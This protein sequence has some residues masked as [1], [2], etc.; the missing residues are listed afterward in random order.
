MVGMTIC[1]QYKALEDMKHKKIT[2]TRPMTMIVPG[3]D[4][5][6]VSHIM[7]ATFS[8]TWVGMGEQLTLYVGSRSTNRSPS[9]GHE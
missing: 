6:I 3:D 8:C 5:K 1:P 7:L 4:I 2:V 9:G